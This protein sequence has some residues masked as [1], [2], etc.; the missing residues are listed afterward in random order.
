MHAAFGYMLE[1]YILFVGYSGSADLRED[2][3]RW[4][5]YVRDAI[6]ELSIDDGRGLRRFGRRSALAVPH[7][8]LRGR[9]QI[10][11]FVLNASCSALMGVVV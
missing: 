3:V 10:F 8:N 5:R 6:I 9:E 11:S 7:G 1:D 4:K 2:E